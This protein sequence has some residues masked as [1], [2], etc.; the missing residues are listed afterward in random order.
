MRFLAN[1][2][3]PALLVELLSI[4]GHDV[5]WIRRDAPGAKDAEVLRRSAAENRVLI[6][7]DKDFG[8][9]VF[10]LGAEASSGVILLRLRGST[11]EALADECMRAIH[12]RED[13]AGQFSVIEP[14]R[15]RMI[16][17]L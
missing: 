11:P 12:G 4:R 5:G 9:L 3:I 13:W 7:F 17:L 15:I 10:R 1:E 2:N 16:R 8:E 6:T 14:G